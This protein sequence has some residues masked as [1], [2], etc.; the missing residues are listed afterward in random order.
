MRIKHFQKF[1]VRSDDVDQI[2][3]VTALQLGGTEFTQ[4]GENLVTDQGK[5]L[6][7]DK[8]VACLLCIA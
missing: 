6:E 8:M 1:N 7:G 2:T 4:S 3:L 5:K